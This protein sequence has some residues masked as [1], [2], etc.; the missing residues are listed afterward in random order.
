MI[1]TRDNALGDYI[2]ETLD[3]MGIKQIDFCKLHYLELGRSNPD[4][5][6]Q[7]LKS[8][9]R[10]CVYGTPGTPKNRELTIDRLS[11]LLEI[12][13]EVNPNESLIAR[14]REEQGLIY[15]PNDKVR[16]KLEEDLQ[17]TRKKHI[18]QLS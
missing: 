5:A 1:K 4:Y 7:Y 8:V 17:K 12:L 3:I 9:M 11:M 18:K 10:G 16:Q 13:S 6:R 2:S 15:P 14:L